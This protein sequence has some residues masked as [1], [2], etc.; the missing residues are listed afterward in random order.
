[1]PLGVAET[2]GG[3]V[4]VLEVAAGGPGAAQPGH[5]LGRLHAVARLGVDGH[6]HIDPP[7]DP[8]GSGEHLIGRRT[9]V[10]LVAQRAGHAPAGGR[11]HGVLRGDHG[12]PRG[13]VPGVRQQEGVAWAV[14]GPQYIA[15]ALEVRC[16]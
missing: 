8:R 9:L 7:D 15:P 14:E 6:G 11:D 16:L 5:Q 10:V 13:H 3:V 4:R 12:S 2:A 1:M